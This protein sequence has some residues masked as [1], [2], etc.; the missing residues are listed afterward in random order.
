MGRGPAPRGIVEIRNGAYPEKIRKRY[1]ID[2]TS[3]RRLN[4][5]KRHWKGCLSLHT[6]CGSLETNVAAVM[7]DAKLTVADYRLV[8]RY[9]DH[10]AT[11]GKPNGQRRKARS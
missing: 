8:I 6:L 2:R 3:F 5:E 7:V 9:S 1:E 10:H 11:D 4:G